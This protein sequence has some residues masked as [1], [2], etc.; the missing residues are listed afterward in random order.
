MKTEFLGVRKPNNAERKAQDC[1]LIFMR[2]DDSGKEYNIF[3]SLPS[4]DCS[5]FQWGQSNDI[6]S[7][8]VEDLEQYIEDHCD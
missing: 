8:N 1:D 2:E 5:W 3:V 7:E 4:G 6:L